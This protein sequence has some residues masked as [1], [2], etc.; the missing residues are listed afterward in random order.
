MKS[1]AEMKL[2][3]LPDGVAGGTHSIAVNCQGDLIAVGAPYSKDGENAGA[4]YILDTA[5]GDVLY[6]LQQP[7]PQMEDNL[8]TSVAMSCDGTNVL[9]AGKKG[10]VGD[11]DQHSQGV[12]YLF[13]IQPSLRESAESLPAAE[14]VQTFQNPEPEAFDEF[15]AAVAMDQAGETIAIASPNHNQNQGVVHV[16]TKN[17]ALIKSFRPSS[18]INEIRA[19]S[20]VHPGLSSQDQFF[21]SSMSLSAD[22]TLLL[23]GAPGRGWRNP[24]PGGAYL[25]HVPTGQLLLSIP[26][27]TAAH[28]AAVNMHHKKIHSPVVSGSPSNDHFAAAVDMSANGDII[29]IGAMLPSSS[30][31]PSVVVNRGTPHQRTGQVYVYNREGRLLDTLESPNAHDHFGMAVSINDRGDQLLVA[32]PH[33]SKSSANDSV[34]QGVAFLFDASGIPIYQFYNPVLE[35]ETGNAPLQFGGAA[36][37]S[38]TGK[39]AA[40]SSAFH[41]VVQVACLNDNDDDDKCPAM[42]RHNQENRPVFVPITVQYSSDMCGVC[43]DGMNATKTGTTNQSFVAAALPEEAIIPVWN[44]TS[45]TV[46]VDGPPPQRFVVVLACLFGLAG[47]WMALLILFH[48]ARTRL[49][50]WRKQ[51]RGWNGTC[52]STSTEESGTQRPLECITCK[53]WGRSE[54][55][56]TEDNDDE[57]VFVVDLDNMTSVDL[58]SPRTPA[59]PWQ[60][61]EH[62]P[63]EAFP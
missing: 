12:V 29:V 49:E 31:M 33:S 62:S 50:L 21:G 4:A 61:F 1:R 57:G 41:P 25:F 37:L 10:F 59:S 11:K 43:P 58:D 28:I 54:D 35:P 16:F 27:P 24:S 39:F 48:L 42:W 2:L 53:V 9:V 3:H 60:Q 8:G 13:G 44:T 36:V 63:F 7:C 32:A 51:R 6:H 45:S 46:P 15:G 47:G 22:G 34:M 19:R 40:I 38:S 5:S 30:H 14:L 26:N 56:S 23:I 52:A 55:F 17:G 18:M 20:A